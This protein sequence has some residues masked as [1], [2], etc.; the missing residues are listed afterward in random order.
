MLFIHLWKYT[1]SIL[2]ENGY[3]DYYDEIAF[4]IKY[5]TTIIKKSILT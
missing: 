5:A 3:Y 4:A 1:L 2:R